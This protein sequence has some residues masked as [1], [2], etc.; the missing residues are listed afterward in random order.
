MNDS[1]ARK[2][3]LKDRLVDL[4]PRLRRFA[5]GIA[6]DRESA[7]ELVQ[8]ACERVLSRF[9]QFRDGTNFESWVFRVLY[10]CW[11][12]GLRRLKSQSLYSRSALYE[13]G[14]ERKRR[15]VTIDATLDIKKALGLLPEEHRAVI[16]LVC[17][18]GYSYAETA[19][20][21]GI[22]AGTVASRV[23]RARK[24]LANLFYGD[25]R[26]RSYKVTEEVSNDG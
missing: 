2:E 1:R 22:P 12:D 7:D 6:K 14:I 9:D 17:V 5:A 26:A 11:L 24:M 18:E 16:M 20:I 15:E 3:M 25:L 4:L 23:T 13:A 21:L 10:T 19:D 8:A